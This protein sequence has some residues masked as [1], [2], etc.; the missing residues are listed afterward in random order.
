MFY[1]TNQARKGVIALHRF[2]EAD[3]R[4]IMSIINS[5]RQTHQLDYDR[6]LGEIKQY[7]NSNKIHVVKN[8]LTNY[9]SSMQHDADLNV[10]THSGPQL[11]RKRIT[12]NIIPSK[13]SFGINYKS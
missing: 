1:R 10:T 2:Y 7:F 5:I 9:F 11:P 8:I 12:S 13:R 4:L 3:D 6:A